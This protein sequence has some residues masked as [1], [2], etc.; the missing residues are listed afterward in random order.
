MAVYNYAVPDEDG[1]DNLSVA[2]NVGLKLPKLLLCERR[3]LVGK[4]RV[5][6]QHFSHLVSVYDSSVSDVKEDCQTIAGAAV[7]PIFYDELLFVHDTPESA[8][9]TQAAVRAAPW[10]SPLFH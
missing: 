7:L 4:F 3:N 6:F 8:G 2:Q 5:N 10:A 9:I 1:V